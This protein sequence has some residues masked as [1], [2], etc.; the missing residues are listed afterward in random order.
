MNIEKEILTIL[1]KKEYDEVL[2]NLKKSFD[3]SKSI[4]RLAIQCTDVSRDDLDTRIRITNGDV[5]LMQKVGKWSSETR[6]EIE[7]PLENSA[8]DV[9]KI[10][11]VL[12]NTMKSEHVRTSIIQTDSLIFEDEKVEIKLTHQFGKSDKYN[13]EIEVRDVSDNP[14][15][16]AKKHNIPMNLPEQ[17][18]EFWDEW[19]KSVNLYADDLSDEELLNIINNYLD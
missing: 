5:H 12:R 18:A 13:A 4:R 2:E 16:F 8:E 3:G 15:N 1:V 14:I 6:S 10:F 9:L 7:I 11:K 17:T 19:S